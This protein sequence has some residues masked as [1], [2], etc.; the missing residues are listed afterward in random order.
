METHAAKPRANKKRK[1]GPIHNDVLKEL[2][3]PVKLYKSRAEKQLELIQAQRQTLKLEAGL[4]KLAGQLREEETKLQREIRQA[5]PELIQHLQARLIPI[6]KRLVSLH[7][8]L[9]TVHMPSA[10]DVVH[11]SY[12]DTLSTYDAHIIARTSATSTMPFPPPICVYPAVTTSGHAVDIGW[13][14]GSIQRDAWY[15]TLKPLYQSF[16]S[17]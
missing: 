14:P 4:R 10:A 12:Y 15:S 11:G 16:R 8:Q 7:A 6:Q 3:R 2:R 13:L 5:D 1:G 17:L 9:D